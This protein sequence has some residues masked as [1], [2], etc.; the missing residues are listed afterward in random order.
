[1]DKKEKKTGGKIL[2]DD[3]L[4]TMDFKAVVDKTDGTIRLIDLQGAYLGGSSSYSGFRSAEEVLDRL[5]PEINDYYITLL[6]EDM[7]NS[8]I[9]TDNADTWEKLVRLADEKM[10]HDYVN[11]SFFK[12]IKAI[13]CF[14]ES[15]QLPSGVIKK[16]VSPAEEE[17]NVLNAVQDELKR[18]NMGDTEAFSAVRI[19]NAFSVAPEYKIAA[20]N[21]NDGTFTVWRSFSTDSGLN[22]GQYGLSFQEAAALMQ[23]ANKKREKKRPAADIQ[24]ER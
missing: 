23:P 15:I 6:T 8:G 2:L 7:E 16:S 5:D 3:I 11:D 12:E 9:D 13:V 18:Q 4:N 21:R 10:P 1:M 24:L 17:R 20:K 19:E 22:F 14:P